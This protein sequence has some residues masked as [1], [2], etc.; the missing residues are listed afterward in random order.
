VGTDALNPLDFIPVDSPTLVDD[1]RAIAEAL[2]V[3]K[4]TEP[5]PHWSEKSVQVICALLV[6]VLMRFDPKER[7]LNSVQDIA[8]DPKLLSAAADILR[9]M[10]G[11]PARLGNQIGGLFGTEEE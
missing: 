8:S 7:N 10:G 5:D 4:G 1:A 6:L 3:R 9:G 11:I 2:V